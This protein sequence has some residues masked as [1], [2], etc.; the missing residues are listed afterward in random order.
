MGLPQSLKVR[1]G[2]APSHLE[3]NSLAEAFN[4]RILSGLGDCA[5]RIFYYAYSTFRGLRNPDGGAYAPEDEWFKFYAYIEPKMSFARFSWPETP[6][7]FP[8]GINVANPFMAWIFGNARRV[9]APNGEKDNTRSQIHGY[10][11]ELGRLDGIVVRA[12]ELPEN[13]YGS[14]Y[15]NGIWFDSQFQ[16]GSAAFLEDFTY[17]TSDSRILTKEIQL[18]S[19]GIVAAARKHLRFIMEGAKSGRYAPSFVPD[20]AGKGG[21]FRKKNGEKDQIG[22][23]MSCYLSYFRGTEDQRARHNLNGKDVTKDGFNF[24][25]FFSRQFLLAPNYAKPIFEEGKDNFGNSK[26]K[27]DGYGY[28]ELRQESEDFYWSYP[29]NPSGG[30]KEFNEIKTISKNVN[31]N[32]GFKFTDSKGGMFF[33]TA[34]RFCLS[35]IMIQSSDIAVKL[36]G[37]QSNMLAGLVIDMYVNENFYQTIPIFDYYKYKVNARSGSANNAIINLR[38]Q[39][40]IYQFNKIHY[41][42]YPVKGMVSFFVRATGNLPYGESSSEDNHGSFSL[43]LRIP[44]SE[45]PKVAGI[46]EFRI[47]IQ[48]A[49]VLEMKPSLADAYVLIRASTASQ[50]DVNPGD[51]EA[52]GHFDYSSSKRIYADYAKFGVAYTSPSRSLLRSGSDFGINET[53]VSA[54]P[55]YE[56]LRKFI[57]SHIK[58]ADRINLIDYGV[59]GGKSVLYFKRFAY[60]M[61]NTGIDIFR[62]LGPSIT[63]VGDRNMVGSKTEVFIPIVKGQRYIVLNTVNRFSGELF[64]PIGDK[65]NRMVHGYRFTGG[66]CHYII[67]SKDLDIG[68]YELEGI[69]DKSKISTERQTPTVIKE[70]SQTSPG[71]ISNEWSMFMSYNL[72]HPASS[73]AFKPEMYGDIMGALNGRCLTNSRALSNTRS[74]QSTS[75]NVKL[76]LAN[77]TWRQF[78]IPLVVEAPSAYNYIEGANNLT[79]T[80]TLAKTADFA[81]SCPIYQKPYKVVSV[82]RLDDFDPKCRIVKVTLDRLLSGSFMNG[83][84]SSNVKDAFEKLTQ[85][86]SRTDE[87][88]VVAYLCHQI[89]RRHCVREVTGD[90]ALDDQKYFWANFRPWGCCYPRFYFV[91]LIPYVSAGS[92][93]YSDHYRQMEYYLRAMCNGF[94]NPNSTL[95]SEISKNDTGIE[96]V[97]GYDSE[98]GDYLFEHLM[99]DSYDN[100]GESRMPMMSI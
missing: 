81:K 73:S 44:S 76:H 58:M 31:I 85:E 91:K 13:A 42:R 26:I 40:Y 61:K 18:L 80:A 90:V 49:H 72:Y 56:S 15:L 77:V 74:K 68:V 47:S 36:E 78:D 54:N 59:E 66:N 7:G 92:V 14:P 98:V 86:T 4:S 8:A 52:V 53:F 71:T 27:Y 51:M 87:S 2:T 65:F 17:K 100:S 30:D 24:E 23:A 11:S 62:G 35:A 96:N 64:Y 28:P 5:W 99:M 60:G 25:D 33:R 1:V 55:I 69:I 37:Q 79:D 46:S 12:R 94:I 10:W 50:K 88:A 29:L 32:A 75:K 57:S 20:Q 34:N 48:F 43:G 70:V 38:D 45:S 22:Q 63:Q 97:G 6:A 82:Q 67:R 9:K 21:I 84:V 83:R 39:Y 41:F 95:T 89:G 3:H 16:R 19:F 93:M